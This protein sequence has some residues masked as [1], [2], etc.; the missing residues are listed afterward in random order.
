[1]RALCCGKPETYRNVGNRSGR[2]LLINDTIGSR[3][4]QPTPR[5][6]HFS[7]E[8]IFKYSYKSTLSTTDAEMFRDAIY[9]GSMCYVEVPRRSARITFF[10]ARSAQNAAR[11]NAGSNDWKYLHT[12]R[13]RRSN[14]PDEPGIKIPVQNKYDIIH[15]TK[16]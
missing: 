12:T 1:M 10:V 2:S 6:N 15:V 13:V 16:G 7:A 3:S 4:M 11:V 14:N 9:I 5:F 8:R